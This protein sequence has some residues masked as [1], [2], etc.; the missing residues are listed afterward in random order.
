MLC[1]YFKFEYQYISNHKHKKGNN[2]SLEKVAIHAEY[3]QNFFRH[4]IS[5]TE[6]TKMRSL[7]FALFVALLFYIFEEV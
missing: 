3:E 1:C 7:F 2:Y 6:L 5:T 4:S